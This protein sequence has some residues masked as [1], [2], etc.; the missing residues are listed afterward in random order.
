MKSTS[1][2]ALD[3]DIMNKM[4][5]REPVIEVLRLALQERVD[6]HLVLLFGSHARQSSTPRSDIDLAVL[7]PGVDILQLSAELSS[8]TGQEI[9]VVMLDR[10]T[11]PLLEELVRDAVVVHEGIRG[12]AASWRSRALAMLETDRPWY[13]R[14]RD[15]W[16]KRVAAGEGI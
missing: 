16:L 9:D 11:I 13:A 1:N 8:A 12:M 14:M 15:A 6:L 10:V 5:K 4:S 3:R 2:P 7:A